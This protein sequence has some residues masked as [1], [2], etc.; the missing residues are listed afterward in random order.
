ML[1]TWE[2]QH[3]GG[4][5]NHPSEAMCWGSSG[6]VFALG[7]QGSCPA[8]MPPAYH[9]DTWAGEGQGCSLKAARDGAKK[10]L[11]GTEELVERQMG[12][13]G[14][15]RRECLEQLPGEEQQPEKSLMGSCSPSHV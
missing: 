8:E 11:E 12:L 4:G 14:S 10:P 5:T 1:Q 3:H 7:R 13:K 9:G 15:S 2:R 6:T